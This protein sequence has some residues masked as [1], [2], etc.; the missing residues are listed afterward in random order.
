MS[1]QSDV[2][3]SYVTVV[4]YNGKVIG[5]IHRSDKDPE[6]TKFTPFQR[7]GHSFEGGTPWWCSVKEGETWLGAETTLEGIAQGYREG[8]KKKCYPYIAIP[9][10][11]TMLKT[12]I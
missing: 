7:A 6:L 5:L 1:K 10:W 4:S 2:K 12:L 9:E 11:I 3:L 8:V